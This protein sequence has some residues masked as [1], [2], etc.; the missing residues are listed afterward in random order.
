MLMAKLTLDIAKEIVRNKE[1]EC[2]S[3]EYINRQ[4]PLEWKYNEDHKWKASV[5]DILKGTWCQRC[6]YRT[7]NLFQYN[8]KND[9]LILI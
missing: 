2:L 9:D 6:I 3:T 4:E 5:K 8:D 1:G 7:K